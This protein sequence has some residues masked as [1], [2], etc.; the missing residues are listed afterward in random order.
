MLTAHAIGLAIVVGIIAALNLRL[1][2]LYGTIP[3]TSLEPLMRVGWIG[4]AINLVTGLSL[5]TTQATV[6][7]TNL[8]FV[9]KIA[10]VMLACANL[11]Y[12]QR[13]LRRD[14]PAWEAAGKVTPLTCVLAGSS[15]LFWVMAV[16]AGRLIAYV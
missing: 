16:V 10:F 3:L 15:L 2:G 5:F 13:V 8:P 12:T 9:L 1:L 4:V 14:A 7:V 6:Y 11:A